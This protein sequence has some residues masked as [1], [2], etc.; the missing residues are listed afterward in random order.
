VTDVGNDVL[1]LVLQAGLIVKFVLLVLVVF[2]VVS[3]GIIVTKFRELRS[4][5]QDGEAFLEVYHTEPF[6]SAYEAGRHLGRSPLAKIFMSSCK[7]MSR[8]AL[9]DG[10]N[11]LAQLDERQRRSVRKVILWSMARE[12]RGL[13]RG[14]TFLATVGSSAP[15]IGLFGTV[16]GIITTFQGIGRSGS[17]SLAV[18]G[19]GIAEALIATGVGLLAAIPASMAYNAFVASID[20]V[21]DSMELFA[22]EFEEDLAAF[23][24]ARPKSAAA[25]YGAP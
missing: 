17:A 19:P 16:V 15:F 14:L 20:D 8:L 21:T 6:D 7:E 22:K 18:V 1:D 23:G 24:T 5:G 10:M 13:E 11:A 2:S 3:W 4:A 12:R 25:R 9:D